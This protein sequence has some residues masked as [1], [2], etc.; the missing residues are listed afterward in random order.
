[1]AVS[2]SSKPVLPTQEERAMNPTHA[3][4]T[5]KGSRVHLTNSAGWSQCSRKI[6]NIE[7]LDG[8]TFDVDYPWCGSCMAQLVD[9]VGSILVFGLEGLKREERAFGFWWDRRAVRAIGACIREYLQDNPAPPGAT[10]VDYLD[11]LRQK[12]EHASE[13]AAGGDA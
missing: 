13:I 7:P 2:L 11:D 1:M 3:G 12:L 10:T 9:G 8:R 6:P 5:P 4:K